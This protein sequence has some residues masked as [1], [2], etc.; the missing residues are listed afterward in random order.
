MPAETHSHR[1]ELGV[2]DVAA[3]VV[4]RI[5]ELLAVEPDLVVGHARLREDLDA[6]DFVLI[7]LFD[8]IEDEIGERTVGFRLDDE[9]LAELVTVN[10]IVECVV[11]RLASAS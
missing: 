9:E 2:D 4:D 1:G 11:A 6:D 3:L 7:D 10:D 8:A 5:S